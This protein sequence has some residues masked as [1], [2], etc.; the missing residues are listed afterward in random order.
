ML[1]HALELPLIEA[2]RQ[3]YQT[4]PAALLPG[5]VLDDASKLASPAL[6]TQTF[7]PFQ[8]A[9]DVHGSSFQSSMCVV[10]KPALVLKAER[11]KGRR[12]L[13]RHLG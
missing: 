3:S 2:P 9:F 4:Y 12:Y 11:Q 10:P 7:Q 6:P 1:R 13:Q 5:T 8:F